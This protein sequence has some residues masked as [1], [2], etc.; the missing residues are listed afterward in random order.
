M[1]VLT[2][3]KV[4]STEF[5]S[6]I[7]GNM[8][9]PSARSCYNIPIQY[10]INQWVEPQDKNMPIM[11]FDDLQAARDFVYDQ[12]CYCINDLIV[13]KCEYIK[14]KKKYGWCLNR[15]EKI[16]ELRAKKKKFSHL[17]GSL[18]NRT[19]FADKIMLVERVMP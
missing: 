3:Y 10:P 19:V 13:C 18:P 9:E 14:S 11:I 6:A 5:K 16:N 12:E 4:V 7:I 8:K 2:G 15:I 17:F 1:K